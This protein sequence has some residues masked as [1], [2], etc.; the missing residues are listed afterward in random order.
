MADKELSPEEKN[1]N[2]QIMSSVRKWLEI[3]NVQQVDIVNRYNIST[4]TI[5][6]WMNGGISPKASQL[7]LIADML[8]IDL[9][10]L[11]TYPSNINSEDRYKEAKEIAQQ[12]DDSAYQSWINIGKQLTK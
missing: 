11:L 5:S 4:G 1:S 6:K 10:T 12:L 2:A 8:G 7:K 9:V 3:K